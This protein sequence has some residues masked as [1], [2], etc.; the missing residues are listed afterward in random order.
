VVL[1]RDGSGNLYAGGYFTAI[2]TVAANHIAMWDGTD[3]HPLGAGTNDEVNAIAIGAS[4]DVFVGGGFTEAGGL[5]SPVNYVARWD[6]SNWHDL[7]GGVNNEVI[8]L[9]YNGGIL[10]AGGRFTLAGDPA[11]AVNYVAS[12]DGSDWSR[13]GADTNYGTDGYVNA[14]ATDNTGA[15][16]VG[17]TF[18]FVG[19]TTAASR[20]AKWN[21][22]WSSLGSGLNGTV[23]DLVADGST[24]YAGGGFTASGALPLTT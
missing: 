16:Y 18:G 4:G 7:D 22:T 13:L 14:L 5:G 15:L 8:A 23:N 19:H 24:I 6:G 12:W 17:G 11:R 20:V 2:G 3:W 21:G 9:H 1:A 10:Y